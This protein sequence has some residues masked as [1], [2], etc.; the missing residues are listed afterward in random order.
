MDINVN[1]TENVLNACIHN[2][3]KHFIL[4]SSSEVYGEP[5]LNPVSEKV[6]TKGKTV[7]AVSKLS[8][9]ESKTYSTTCCCLFL[10]LTELPAA[11]EP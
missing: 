3:V 6:E 7:Y 11:G 9:E 4:A 10:N 2:D 8:A 5:S 1:G